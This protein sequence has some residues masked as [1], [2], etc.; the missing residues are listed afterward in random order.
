[1][2][3][4][5]ILHGGAGSWRNTP[6][7]E[8]AIETV[9]ECTVKAYE[10]LEDKDALTAVVSA[11]KCMEDSGYLNAGWG[12]VLDLYGGR[13]L[14]AGL[15]T[16]NGLIGAVAAVTATKN[17]ILLAEIVALETPHILIGGLGAD[18]LAY[19]Y[20]LPPLPP[21]PQHVWRR[22]KEI[23]DK[24]LRGEAKTRY[25]RELVKYINTRRE[26]E[27]LLREIAGLHDTVGA[28]ALD[29]EGVLAAAVSTGGV[30]MKLPGRI[31]DSPVPGA[32]FYATSRVACSATG[33]GEQIILSMPC[34]RLADYM[35]KGLDFDEALDKVLEY[36]NKTVGSNTMGFIAVNSNGE[37]GWRYNT[38]AMLIGYIDEKGEVVVKDK[39]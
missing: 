23:L 38:E 27:D 5:I 3:K 36:V 11:V 4:R 33:Y 12:S 31:G 32:G 6:V 30:I 35:E 13:S 19:K 37:V 2:V 24:L 39:P 10:I 18:M 14:D 9:K 22:Y 17:P 26:V 16:S 28:V 20:N 25:G 1:M 7:K 15:M 34:L 8:K 21:P 29:D